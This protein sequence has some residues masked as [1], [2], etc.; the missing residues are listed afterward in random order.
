MEGSESKQGMEVGITQTAVNELFTRVREAKQLEPT[1]HFS[2][3]VSFLQ[4]YN[5]KVFDLLNPTSSPIAKRGGASATGDQAGLR[6]R[7]TKKD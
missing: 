1:R 5:E 2:I 3:L 7:W 6:I 4:I